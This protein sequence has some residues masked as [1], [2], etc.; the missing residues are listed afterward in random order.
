MLRSTR[1]TRLGKDGRTIFRTE[2]HVSFVTQFEKVEDLAVGRVWSRLAS[3]HSCQ[4]S[5]I[6]NRFL[7]FCNR[8]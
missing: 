4:K 5:S 2:E 1:T 3:K 6:L 7:R 8:I